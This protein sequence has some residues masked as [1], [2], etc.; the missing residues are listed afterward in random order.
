MRVAAA[1]GGEQRSAG[2]PA[3]AGPVPARDPSERLPLLPTLSVKP[4]SK[5]LAATQHEHGGTDGTAPCS[6][7]NKQAFH[8]VATPKGSEHR[9]YTAAL[10]AREESFAVI[11]QD[12]ETTAVITGLGFTS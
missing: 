2:R 5:R 3:Q 7:G 11:S 8:L 6:G 9:A 1:A 4:S 12:T 10:S